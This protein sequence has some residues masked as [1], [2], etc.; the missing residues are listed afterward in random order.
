MPSLHPNEPR[1]GAIILAAGSSTRLGRAKQL[2]EIDGE[3]MLRRATRLTL[4]T[5]PIDTIVVLRRGAD[6]FAATLAESGAR[7]IYIEEAHEGMSASLRA[8]VAALDARCDGALVVLTDQAALREAHLARLCAAWR[9]AP[10]R[11]AAS[12]YAGVIGTPALLPR[13]WFDA[14]AT[15]RGDVGAR[16]LLRARSAYTIAIAAPELAHDIDTPADLGHARS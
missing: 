11:A 12:A 7:T 10:A 3:P 16:A 8:G 2:V 4:A 14:I 15:L 9:D 6:D 5:D 13:A 1:H